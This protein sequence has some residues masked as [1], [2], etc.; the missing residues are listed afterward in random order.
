MVG[1]V[2][3]KSDDVLINAEGRFNEISFEIEVLA[4]KIADLQTERERI[5]R[6]IETWRE[7]ADATKPSPAPTEAKEGPRQNPEAR[8]RSTVK[9]PSRERIRGEVRILLNVK[10][11][12]ELR[13]DV[14]NYLRDQGIEIFG[15]DPKMVFSTMMWRMQ[16][17]FVRIPRWG[18]WFRDRPYAPAGYD[19]R[20]PFPAAEEHREMV[21]RAEATEIRVIEV[22][23]PAAT[24]EAS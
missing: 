1:R 3:T 7:F 15:K 9:N 13:K 17:E 10:G 4:K 14:F 21:R 18:Y 6:F 24:P 23:E 19:P 8:T 20:L 16:D 11:K 5:R 22:A 12:P 2:G